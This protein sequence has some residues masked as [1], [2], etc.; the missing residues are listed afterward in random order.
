MKISQSAQI[1]YENIDWLQN[2]TFDGTATPWYSTTN[3]DLSDIAANGGNGMANCSVLG[4]Q[5]SI[6]IVANPPNSSEWKKFNNTAFPVLPNQGCGIDSAGC[7]ASHIWDEDGPFQETGQTPSVHWKR[8]ITMPVNMS[9]YEITSAT[10]SAI[11]NASVLQDIDCPGDTNSGG[12][13]GNLNGKVYDYV[14][15]YV[16]ISDLE[17]I[18]EYEVAYNKTTYLG[19]GDSVA[20]TSIMPDTYLITVSEEDLIFYLTSVLESDHY[21][22]TITLGIFIYCEDNDPDYELDTWTSLRIKFFN[23]TFSYTK[24]INRFSTIAWNQIGNKLP[25]PPENG[26]LKIDSAILEFKCRIDQDWIT[27][28]PNSEIRILINGYIHTETIKLNLLNNS[29]QTA[30]SGGF[31]VTSLIAKDVNI[32]VSIQVY[33]ADNFR[34]S[35]NRTISLDNVTLKITYTMFYESEIPP[36]PNYLWLIILLGT[37]IAGLLAA[38][39][40]YQ[41]YLS[42]IHI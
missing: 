8:N 16:L 41:F 7:W 19:A 28:S 1:K 27:D 3:G 20:Q 34:L 22:F 42:L 26:S 10:L 4:E 36:G 35:T 30:K 38:W 31:D 12:T 6:S 11:V 24:K 18:R 5:G 29:F 25:T 39:A 17:G 32:T 13:D 14:R 2:T 33:L 9:D 15:F 23:L 37:I 40:T 21:N